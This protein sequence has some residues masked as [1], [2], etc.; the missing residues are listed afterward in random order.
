MSGRFVA[1]MI[2]TLTRDSIP[3]ISVN[4]WLITRSETPLSPK[5]IP[6]LGTTES[7]SSK[8]TMEGA[9]VR[10]FLKTSR[11]AYSDPLEHFGFLDRPFNCFLEFLFDLGQSSYVCPVHRGHF[12]VDL[13]HRGR[14]NFSV[15][16]HKVLNVDFHFLQ[17]TCGYPLL[18]E[19]D[20]GEIPSERFHRALSAK[21]R[22]VCASVT[23]AEVRETVQVPVRC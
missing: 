22:Y 6:L 5:P 21:G 16:V 20:L 3:S 14:R 13:P 17:D 1:P 23:V 7:S 18:F 9:A 10:P 19:I 8:K 11:I 2:T 12:D 15:R 4:S